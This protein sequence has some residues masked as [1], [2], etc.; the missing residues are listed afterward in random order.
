MMKEED[1]GVER[2]DKTPERME[3]GDQRDRRREGD[4][5]IRVVES[6]E[7]PSRLPLAQIKIQ[8]DFWKLK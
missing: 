4:L 1:Y 3:A 8:Q 6:P 5:G 7:S 2:E